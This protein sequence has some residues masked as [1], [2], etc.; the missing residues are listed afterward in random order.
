MTQYEVERRA[1]LWL[2]D[3]LPSEATLERVYG[4][5]DYYFTINPYLRVR[6]MKLVFQRNLNLI[7]PQSIQKWG[8]K[9]IEDGEVEETEKNVNALDALKILN[10]SLG[11]PKV[12]V[13][14]CRREYSLRD[15]RVCSD[16]VMNLGFWTEVEKVTKSKEENG[17]ALR[18]V[19]LAFESFG[20]KKDQLVKELYPELLLKKQNSM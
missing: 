10:D 12:I 2:E 18:E 6:D 15:L 14:G 16:Y 5:R 20:V 1:N 17:Q 19:E 7:C 8:V 4:G 13:E 11:K 3:R 9:K